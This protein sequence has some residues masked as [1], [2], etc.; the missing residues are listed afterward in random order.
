MARTTIQNTIERIRR[1]MD[2]N[3][4][5]EVNT[6]GATLTT[7]TN[8]V[9]LT[10]DLANSVRAGA[11]LSV[12]HELMRVISI[13]AT[14]KE[15]TVL[16]GWL[17]TD[18]AA[19]DQNDEVLINPRFTRADIYDAIIQEIDSWQPDIFTATDIAVT[20]AQD[21]QGFE[22]P[23]ANS[24]ALG[25]IELRRN[26]TEDESVVWPEF[27]YVLHRG[28]SASLTPNEGTGLFVRFTDH[29]G[30][31]L[32]AGTVVARLAIPYDSSLIVDEDSDLVA[33]VGIDSPLLELI[34][35]GVK[36]RLLD[37]SEIARSGRGIQDEPRRA[38]EV[39][40]GAAQQKAQGLLQRYE[41]RR[42]QEV[43]RMRQRYPF[44]AW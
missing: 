42:H 5:L 35:L 41:R 3:I 27:N 36:A 43:D 13:N 7:T 33:D 38:E 2:S 29:G 9:T 6:L 22:V 1:Q 14:S 30:R 11:V 23:S 34:E 10:Y 24:N 8:P 32:K 31:A 26:F 19:H 18:A 4:R 39:P 21:D 44:K 15:V 12:G 28:R 17:D 25:V 40:P 16:R 20:I 37:D